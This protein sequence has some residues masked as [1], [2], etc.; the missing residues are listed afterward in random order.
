MKL[1]KA[2]YSPY[3][4]SYDAGFMDA[5][6]DV[7]E[8]RTPW[9]KMRLASIEELV[10]PHPGDRVLDLGCAAGSMAHFLSTF[11]CVSAGVDDAP[12]AIEAARQHYPELQFELASSTDLPF[13]AASFDKIVAADF[14]EHLDEP[15]L[16]RTFDECFRVLRPGGTLSIHTPNPR[17]LIERLKAHEILLAQ[18]PTHTG[19][20]TREELEDELR[21]AGFEIELSVWRRSFIPVFRTIELVGGRVTELLRY[22]ICIRARRP[23]G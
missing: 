12:A 7:Y 13:P 14:T 6:A 23:S 10:D 20:R 9:T 4:D 17:H 21:K 8:R 22:R 16:T 11:G 19:L 18:N 15:T 3:R 5:H 1:R 2:L